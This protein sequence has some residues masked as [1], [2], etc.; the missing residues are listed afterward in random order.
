MGR[1]VVFARL[2]R[3]QPADFARRQAAVKWHQGRS[4]SLQRQCH[5]RQRVK[6]HVSYF[7]SLSAGRSLFFLPSLYLLS[8]RAPW[9]SIYQVRQYLEVKIVPTLSR[10]L[11][12]MVHEVSLQ[13]T[14]ESLL[15]VC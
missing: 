14:D 7:L 4:R 15:S 8:S 10:A 5:A 12:E 9:E 6:F 2:R 3:A 11:T 1:S 13:H